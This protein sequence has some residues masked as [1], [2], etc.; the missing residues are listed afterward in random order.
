MKQLDGI[1]INVYGRQSGKTYRQIK[2]KVIND[3]IKKINKH[4]Y[5]NNDDELR[6]IKNVKSIIE[7]YRWE[8]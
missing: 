2:N 3:I 6:V 5:W 7:R 1:V 8:D 4:C